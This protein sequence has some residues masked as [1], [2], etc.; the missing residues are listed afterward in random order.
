MDSHCKI[1]EA[2]F[3]DS[4]GLQNCMVSAYASYQERMGSNRLP[5]MD[6]DYASE[7]RNYPTWVVE[8]NGQI[9][10]GLI[11]VF[12]DK[13]AS[14][15]NIAGSPS[16]QGKGLGKSLMNFAESQARERRYSELH[17]ATH[18]LLVENIA[19]YQHLGWEITAQDDT[20]VLM[21]KPL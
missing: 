8:S 18:R 11:M 1:R 21:K 6:V 7:I 3:E 4:E 16:A 14:I 19:L 5:P 12:E 15:A 2:T 9:L 17:L 20:K 13:E 10:G